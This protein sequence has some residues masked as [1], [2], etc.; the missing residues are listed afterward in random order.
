MPFGYEKFR[1]KNGIS[2]NTVVHEV[3]LIEH[4]LASVSRYHNGPIEPH[5]IRPSDI[6][7]FFKEQRDKGL[8]DNTIN[9]KL[10]FVRK[11]F[12]YMWQIGKIPVDFMPKFKLPEKLDLTPSEIDLDYKELLG[13]QEEIL[14]SD[15]LALYA[16]IL[17]LLYMRGLRVRDMTAIDI[18]RVED[19]GYKL[20]LTVDK[21]DGYTRPLDFMGSEIP[22]IQKGIDLA[23]ERGTPFLLASKVKDNYTEFQMGSLSDYTDALAELLGR[24]IRSGDIRFAYVRH[25]YA[26]EGK[27][28]EEIQEALGITLESA[29]RILKEAL[30]RVRPKKK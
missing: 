2:P 4:L 5:E 14:Q 10:V 12:D 30:T 3:Q 20:R 11:W 1:L 26:E 13:R 15:K 23:H 24:P 22:I 9:R 8:K 29:A 27:N 19:F 25:L 18:S 28:V 16:K 7:R 21:K 17:F 6:Q